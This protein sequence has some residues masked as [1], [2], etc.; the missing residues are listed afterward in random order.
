VGNVLK[1]DITAPGV[2]IL[3]QGY[4]PG[5]TGEARHLGWGQVSGTSMAAPHVTGAAA[6]L[7]Q[8]H[9]TW[10][11]AAIKSALMSTSKFVGIWNS[12]TSH[13]QPLDMGA[14][15]LDLTNA[16]D[17]GVILD[18]PS[19]SFGQVVTGTAHTLHVSVTSVATT[20]ETYDAALWMVGG[21]Y[22]TPTVTAGLPGFSVDPI[23]FTLGAGATEMISVTFDTTQGSLGDNQGYITLASANYAG[24]PA[25]QRRCADHRQ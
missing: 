5:A 22:P 20:T 4:T 1:P 2:N 18:P 19:V 21:T 13:A 24:F 12:P 3:A 11:N 8:I 16:A 7:R 15:R 9:P 25:A 10:S 14:G 6:L 23:S 17:P